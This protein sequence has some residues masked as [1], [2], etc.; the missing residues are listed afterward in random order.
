MFNTKHGSKRTKYGV[1]QF[2]IR[3]SVYRLKPFRKNAG[4]IRIRIFLISRSAH[5]PHFLITY[6]VALMMKKM[7]NFI[8]FVRHLL[9][10]Q[11][12]IY[13][14]VALFTQLLGTVFTKLLV[15]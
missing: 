2:K 15:A 3:H 8:N 7:K 11:T 5:F 14:I 9:R 12:K 4:K 10:K 6:S 1:F 13:E